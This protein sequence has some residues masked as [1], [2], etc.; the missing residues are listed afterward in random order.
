MPHVNSLRR[1]SPWTALPLLAALLCTLHLSAQPVLVKDINT[2]TEKGGNSNP[3]QLCNVNGTLFFVSNDGVNGPELWKTDGTA[4]GTVL[5]KN[6][7]PGKGG[8]TPQTLTNVNGTLFFMADN[9]ANGR[10]LWKSDG[11]AAGTVMVKDIWPGPGNSYP[12]E[13]ANVN[14]TLFFAADNG[15]N[16]REL[17]KSDGTE[18]GTVMVRNIQ[19]E[20]GG[21]GYGSNPFRL[22]NVNGTLYFNVYTSPN[23][24]EL[25]KSDGTTNGTVR[26]KDINP[27]EGSSTIEYLTSVNGTLYFITNNGTNGVVLWR[28]NGTDAGTLP[29]K[30]FPVQYGVY[31]LTNVNG[32]LFLTADD[33]T[34]GAEL[35][36][37]NGTVAGTTLVKDIW[38]GPSGSRV[39]PLASMGNTL[40]FRANDGVSGDELWKSDGTA[41]G[42]VLV[43]DIAPGSDYAHPYVG[44]IMGGVLYFDAYTGANGKE[45]W[46]TDGTA[47]GT[48]PL[49]DI[50]AGWGSSGV[51]FLTVANNTLYLS[52]FDGIEQEL[53]KSNGTE[54][55]TVRVKNIRPG[56]NGSAPG[57]LTN[58]NGTA[59]FTA[60][61]GISGDELWKSN[62]TA[63]GTLP[64]RDIAP[65]AISANPNWLTNV[66]GTLYFTAYDGTTGTELWK[67]DGITTTRVKDILPGP[68]GSTPAWLTNMSGT[69]YFA[70]EDGMSGQELW[71]SDGTE[72]G[73]VRVK[74]I[75]PGTGYAS[76]AMLTNVNGTLYFVAYD[77]A[78]GQELWRS[79]GTADGTTLIKDIAPGAASAFPPMPY[80]TSSNAPRLI[81]QNGILY[82]QATDGTNGIE[83][84]RS[85]GTAAGTRLV[86][87]IYPGAG[88]AFSS[89]YDVRK[90]ISINGTVYFTADD[91]VSGQELWKTD[92]TAAGTVRV[93]DGMPG[94]EHSNPSFLT[95]FKGSL[96]FTAY[97]TVDGMSGYKLW[98]SDG[99]AGGTVALADPGRLNYASNLMTAGNKLYFTAYQFGNSGLYGETGGELWY[100]DGTAAGTLL[101]KDIEVGPESSWPAHLTD[102]NGTLYFSAGQT[103][104]GAELWKYAPDACVTPNAAL[105]VTGSI[106]CAGN[107]ASVSVKGSQPGVAYQLY[108]NNSPLGEPAAGGG[109]ISIALPRN[110]LVP[111]AY[112]LTVRASGCVEV[113][114][115]QQ[116]SVEVIGPIAT[117]TVAAVAV[118]PGDAALLTA[119]GAPAGTTYRWYGAAS[120]GSILA[121]GATFTTPRLWVRTT[122][123]AAVY[124][125]TTGCESARVAVPVNINGGSQFRINAG[126]GGFTMPEGNVFAADA[127]FSGGTVSSVAGGEVANTTGD[128]LYRNMRIG[129]AFAYNLPTGS[130]TFD[131]TLH[132]NETYWGYRTTGGV[133]SRQ[134][135]VDLEGSRKLT[136]YDI[137][138]K[139]GGAM[140]ARSETFRV[141]VADG[142]LNIA[143]GKGLADNPAVAA[144][145]AV[146]VGDGLRVNAGGGAYTTGSGKTFLA[147]TYYAGG[148]L[149]ALVTANVAGTTDDP[150]YQ[151]GRHGAFS[152]NLPVAGG[153][154]DVV[155]HFNETYWGHLAAGGAGSRRFNV[156]IEGSRRLTNY[157][158]FAKAGG[159]MRAVSETFRVTVTDATLNI[160]F[161]RGLADQPRVAALEV[162]PV[163]GSRV[164]AAGTGRGEA[165]GAV[166]Y[167]NPVREKL[168]VSLDGPA[169]GVT[170]T[171]LT[172]AL[173]VVR[174]ANG[175]RVKDAHTLE[176]DV[177]PLRPGTY[178][179]TLTTAGGP[180]LLRFVK[181]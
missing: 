76:P 85:D 154:Y 121:T 117:P 113:T 149:S 36:K 60:N 104:R 48:V 19:P 3:S 100:S 15:M 105:T 46:K 86:K 159:A 169:E 51:Q 39:Q 50:N 160:A 45:L 103:S 57:S 59:Y 81:H 11:T 126:G 2:R 107:P 82:L 102:V 34:N 97:A 9:G 138:A 38:P 123:Y 5:V 7:Y 118:N 75:N 156:D 67:S 13:M 78:G 58:V 47:A 16:G 21:Y 140:K 173:G 110:L 143:F 54:A 18:A 33:G 61:D 108:F 24:Q 171:A 30:T 68:A 69:L 178:L 111:A 92:G 115:A 88:S 120:G 35:W 133:G 119:G 153:T 41:I 91:G 63:A 4:A 73:T 146:P 112:V 74:D 53:W 150:L 66:N 175:H 122:Y 155:L 129:T 109:D 163:A 96:Y 43:K 161:T 29:L 170:G 157:D 162:I 147:D 172:D 95:N 93:I 1:W 28:S 164:A 181:Q 6:I 116:A 31:G 177:R 70:A 136:N 84:W 98:K 99:T 79:N 64:V 17:W 106:V 127:Y 44:V 142:T 83:L 128:D 152:Y 131:V 65:G 40:Y 27:G 124:A 135:N 166:L 14:G 71:K 25:W 77:A 151:T 87:D 55:G 148:A 167:P 137:F 158:I 52:A 49:K 26:V 141:T 139:A 134:F 180:C 72:A 56:S 37:S 144:I 10:E 42:T 32:T 174:L 168:Y 23:G 62:G 179:L 165:T 22:T 130:G 12:F 101:V 90:M 89:Y 20:T 125:S 94:P 80:N 145:E 176:V 114:L 8:P 132:F